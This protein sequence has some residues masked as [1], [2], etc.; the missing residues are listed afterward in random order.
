MA[1]VFVV[2]REAL[3]ER[4]RSGYVGDEGITY[5][6]DPL[7]ETLGALWKLVIRQQS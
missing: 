1:R 3:A 2:A 7:G 5:D 4:I 6:R